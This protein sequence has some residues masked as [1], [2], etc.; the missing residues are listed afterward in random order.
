MSRLMFAPLL[1]DKAVQEKFDFDRGSAPYY[2]STTAGEIRE[3]C[4]RWGD[5]YDL[6]DRKD[7]HCIP[8]KLA[9]KGYHTLAMHSFT[10][11]FFAREEWYPNI[12]F[13]QMAFKNDMV[14][15]GSEKC[16]G[17]SGRLRS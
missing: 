13:Q 10:P 8:A 2:N 17:F 16:G 11:K 1:Q 3:L 9:A 5:Y 14:A 12:G 7:A 15:A 4:G 6:V